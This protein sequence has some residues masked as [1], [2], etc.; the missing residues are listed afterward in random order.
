[1]QPAFDAAHHA[2]ARTAR[3]RSSCFKTSSVAT[4]SHSR[5]GARSV[6]SERHDAGSRPFSA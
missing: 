4:D 5:S 6:S 1:L 3:C 2:P